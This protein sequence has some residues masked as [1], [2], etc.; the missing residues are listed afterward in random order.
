MNH[1]RKEREE[2]RHRIL[3][4]LGKG[5]FGSV[6]LRECLR[7]R[8]LHAVKSTEVEYG[9]GVPATTLREIGI[10]KVLAHTNIIRL[11]DVEFTAS[12][13]DLVLEACECDLKKCMRTRGGPFAMEEIRHL[14]AQL[15]E[16]IT[17]LHTRRILHRDLK[18]Q[19]LLLDTTM[20][21]LKICDFG[22]ARFETPERDY[23][24]EV[25]T[26]W[27]RPPELLLGADSYGTELDVWCVGC[28]LYEMFTNTPAFAGD[29]E[30]ETLFR[31]FQ[32]LGRPPPG[33]AL[34]ALPHWND[35]TFPRW[36]PPEPPAHRLE[37]LVAMCLAL[38]PGSRP[39][40]RSCL[41]HALF[42]PN[43]SV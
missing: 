31:V 10:L 32:K 5:S 21:T 43:Q 8:A 30:I 41:R 39:A 35:D 26:L 11:I 17:F 25:V 33:S 36:G 15:F 20:R 34:T 9:H 1:K 38:D 3:R 27:Y 24:L 37:E 12:T 19:N 40:S 7:T 22:L 42:D 29:S 23:T 28:V 4:T 18:P 16:G 2:H 13:V 14:G 6:C